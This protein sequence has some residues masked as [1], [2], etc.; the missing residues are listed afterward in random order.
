M[1]NTYD[2]FTKIIESNGITPYRVAKDS[3]IQ[4]NTDKGNAPAGVS[5]LGGLYVTQSHRQ[6][7]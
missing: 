5:F 2:L 7:L 6:S 3:G 1:I 4:Q